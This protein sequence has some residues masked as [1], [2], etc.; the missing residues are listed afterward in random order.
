MY[1]CVCVCEYVSNIREGAQKERCGQGSK[2]AAIHVKGQE[3]HAAATQSVLKS[4]S[5]FS[6]AIDIGSQNTFDA[7]HDLHEEVRDLRVR[8]VFPL[9]Q[10]AHENVFGT[11]AEYRL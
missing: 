3:L 8:E 2:S 6:L 11:I 4:T 7:R 5:S 9:L 10:R 1:M